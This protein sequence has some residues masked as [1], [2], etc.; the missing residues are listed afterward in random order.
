M[1]NLITGMIGFYLLVLIGTTIVT[2]IPTFEQW[3]GSTLM[4][5]GIMTM[6]IGIC[7]YGDPE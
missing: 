1:K 5:V 3:F 4:Y 7:K 6:V 2:G